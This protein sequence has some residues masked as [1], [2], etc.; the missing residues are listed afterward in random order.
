LVNE[1]PAAG[2]VVP[3]KGFSVKASVAA[4]SLLKGKS[5]TFTITV[6]GTG[7]FNDSVALTA[8]TPSGVTLTFS[9]VSVKPGVTSTATLTVSAAV[10]AGL[11]NITITGTSAGKTE[12]A[13]VALT[14]LAAPALTLGV[15]A[16]KVEVAQ[17]ASGSLL[18]TTTTGGSF[19]G[20]VSLAVAGL[21]SGV[22]ATW[23]GGSYT[24]SVDGSTVSTLT[25]KPTTAAG[26]VSTSFK[27]IA[28]GDGLTATVTA[29]VQV[30][31]APAISIALS[32]ATISMSSMSTQ[33]L[34]AT[35]SS[36][37]GVSLP[38][39]AAFKVTG[40]PAGITG[41]WG[42]ANLTATGALQAKLTL[43]GSTS[44]VSSST[45]P[46]IAVTATDSVSGKVYSASEAATLTVTR[47]L[48]TLALSVAAT[49]VTLVQG[50]SGTLQVTTTTGGSYTGLVTLGVAGLPAGVTATWAN[51]SFTQTTAGSATSTLTLKATTT[52]AVATIVFKITATDTVQVTAAPA[53]AMALSPATISLKSTAKQVVT[54][55]VTPI[56]AASLAT[57]AASFKVTGLPGGI[58]SSWGVASR[59][60]AGALQEQLT[61]TGSVNAVAS[62]SK[63]TV[64]VSATD[65]VSGGV[66]TGTEQ[67]TLT[68]TKAALLRPQ[69]LSLQ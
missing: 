44:V 14:V 20:V 6:T 25:L 67:A 28:T 65:T 32:P 49:K 9:P 12:T 15:N 42:V 23:T 39:S 55:T 46:V 8:T 54:V 37:G 61:L 3:V 27:I 5:A 53:I 36:V 56:G 33:S 22:A 50:Q 35:V 31:A 52:A 45:K 7:G 30:T 24:S 4:E 51:G 48:P 41:N 21:P 60:A 62:T 2:V 19:S 26:L 18:M 43:T 57:T 13:T 47:V 58:S 11:S 17:G 1:W 10:A 59:T 63:P 69:P 40:L 68:V 38:S 64:T 66:Y 16:T 29:T 34:T